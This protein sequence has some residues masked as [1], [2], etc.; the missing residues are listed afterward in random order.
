MTVTAEDFV[1]REVGKLLRVDHRGQFLC[2]SC[3]KNIVGERFGNAYTR[4]QI[5][6]AAAAVFKSPGGLTRMH[7]FICDRCANTIPCLGSP[8]RSALSAQTREKHPG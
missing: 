4:G 2:S 7:A 3:L 8:R 5:E 1:R 6:R